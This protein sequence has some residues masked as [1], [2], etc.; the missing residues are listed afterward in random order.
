MLRQADLVLVMDAFQQQ[1]VLRRQPKCFGSVYRLGRWRDANIPD[2]AF[3]ASVS[4]S[5]CLTLIRAC[6]QDWARCLEASGLLPPL[7][8]TGD[9]VPGGSSPAGIY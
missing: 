1:E 9:G 6:L 3:S 5:A 2:P 4:A 7:Y 8:L